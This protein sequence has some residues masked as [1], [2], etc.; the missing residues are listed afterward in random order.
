MIDTADPLCGWSLSDILETSIGNAAYDLY[1]KLF[2]H[3][4][5]L[6]LSFKHRLSNVGATF[7]LHNLEVADLEDTLAPTTFARIEVWRSFINAKVRLY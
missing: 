3:V 1:G 2:V 5:T 4:A 6:L 7:E